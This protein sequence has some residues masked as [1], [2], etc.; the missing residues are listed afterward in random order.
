MP[1]FKSVWNLHKLHN[2]KAPIGKTHGVSEM[3][4][5]CFLALPN[6]ILKKPQDVGSLTTSFDNE[7]TEG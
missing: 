6:L 5:K 4:T 1:K 3:E 7:D 2:Y